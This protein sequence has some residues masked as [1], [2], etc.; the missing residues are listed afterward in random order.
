MKLRIKA[1]P[2]PAAECGG[3]IAAAFTLVEVLV[4]ILILGTI[5]VA[6]YGALS[7]GFGLVQSTREDLR[8]TQILMQKIEAI[9]LCTWYE[10][11][12]FSFREPYDPMSTNQSAGAMYYGTV[13][14][15]PATSIPN[16]SAYQPRMCLVTVS[17]SWTNFNTP[18]PQPHTRQMQTEVARYGMQNYIWGAQ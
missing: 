15:G 6:Y 2:T 17:L 1:Q 16:T 3:R 8:A 14:T 13:T 7:S 4:A 18:R 11:T 5:S 9:R 12:N 10:L